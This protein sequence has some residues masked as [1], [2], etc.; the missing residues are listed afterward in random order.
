MWLKANILIA[1]RKPWVFSPGFSVRIKRYVKL[2]QRDY[3]NSLRRKGIF[4]YKWHYE[5]IEMPSSPSLIFIIQPL[6]P[7]NKEDF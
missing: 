4:R 6:G 3:G 1:K 5:S 2:S 7:Y